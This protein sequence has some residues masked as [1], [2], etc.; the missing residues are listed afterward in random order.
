[1]SDLATEAPA[2]TAE[3]KA[4]TPS[5][6]GNFIWYELMTSD[7]DAAIDFYEKVVGW[8]AA[9][10]NMADLGDFRY[11]LLSVGDRAVAGL[12]QLNEEMCAGGAKPGWVGV[13]GVADT[14]AAAKSIEAAGGAILKAPDDIPNVGRFAIVAD[15]GGAVFE[16]MTPIPPE[17]EPA[18]LDAETPGKF[19]WHELY[20]SLGDKAAI[21]F[22]AG[23][24]GWVTEN[25][26]DMGPMGIYR[27]FGKDG[28]QLGGMMLKPADMPV[29]AWG[30]YV[31]VEG[32]D[33]AIERINANGGQ[34]QIGPHE[35][36]GG[37]WIVQATDPQGAFFALV[38][39]TR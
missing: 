20:S 4:E 13:I 10:Q 30:F 25:A 23:Q 17:Q 35:I 39:R 33:A 16:L 12:M 18:P 21:D 5:W 29:S 19:S 3:A 27:I 6:H 36:P 34:V 7:Q 1:M 38:S 32:I 9:D 14:D 11:T 2:T 28:V 37:G 15:P 24:F 8:T 22:Y 31:N 26:M